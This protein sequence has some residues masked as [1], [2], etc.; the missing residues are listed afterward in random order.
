MLET[1]LMHLL[2]GRHVVV[3]EPSDDVVE[4]DLT[5][6]CKTFFDQLQSLLKKMLSSAL[7]G[8]TNKSTDI[9]QGVPN[10]GCDVRKLK[11][12]YRMSLKPVGVAQLNGMYE[13]WA[14]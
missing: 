10:R 5:V 12:I 11:E 1:A 14:S 8:N 4:S 2:E 3:G 7:A 6:I 13:L 9:H